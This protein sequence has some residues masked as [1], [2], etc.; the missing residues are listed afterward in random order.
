MSTISLSTR[1]EVIAHY[2]SRLAEPSPGRIG[3]KKLLPKKD[4]EILVHGFVD[5]LIPLSDPS[6]IDYLVRQELVMLEAG[7][8]N[9]ELTQE[10]LPVYIYLIRA[11]IDSRTLSLPPNKT[12]YPA[13]RILLAYQQGESLDSIPLESSDSPVIDR[14]LSLSD[15]AL[16]DRITE[17]SDELRKLQDL[18]SIRSG[19]APNPGFSMPDTHVKSRNAFRKCRMTIESVMHWNRL[20]EPIQRFIVNDRLIVRLTGMRPEFV[21]AFITGHSDSINQHH[22]ELN[23]THFDVLENKKN[24]WRAN[25]LFRNPDFFVL[26][27]HCNKRLEFSGTVLLLPQD[28]TPFPS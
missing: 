5:L 22:L 26:L 14:L 9:W 27:N 18:Y 21:F 17:L 28:I 6:S 3:R 10:Y 4:F 16:L 1:D 8:R 15:P 13:L 23:I 20:A 19:L 25:V 12:L 11:A 2:H 24:H 7:L